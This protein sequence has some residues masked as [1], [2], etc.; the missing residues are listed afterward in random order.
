MYNM[1]NKL[2]KICCCRKDK[3]TT[4]PI[5]KPTSKPISQEERRAIA[6]LRVERFK[7]DPLQEKIDREYK[8]RD[9]EYRKELQKDNGRSNVDP[10]DWLS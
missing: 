10:N 8:K 7:K 4:K 2:K 6:E 1:F 3:S 5:S 9:E